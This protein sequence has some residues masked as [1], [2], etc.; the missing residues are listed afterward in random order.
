VQRQLL[1]LSSS[2]PPPKLKAFK[3]DELPSEAKIPGAKR[4]RVI[5]GPYKIKAA[6]VCVQQDGS[7]TELTTFK[8]GLFATWQW[9]IYGQGWH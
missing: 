2:T 6:N 7:F 9:K 5:Y 4:I 3:I 1:G 8:S